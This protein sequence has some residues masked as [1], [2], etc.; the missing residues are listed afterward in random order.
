MTMLDRKLI[1]KS[2]VHQHDMS[3]C[4]TACL[5]TLIRYYGGDSS[6]LHLREISGTSNT[7][8]TLLGLYQAALTMGFD[9]NGAVANGIP[10]LIEHGKP[11]ILAVIVDKLLS[12]YVVCYGLEKDRFIISD[13]AKGIVEMTK[14]ELDSVWTKNCLLLEPNLNFERKEKIKGKKKDW[15]LNLIRADFGLLGSSVAFGLAIAVLGMVM[16]VFSQRLVDDVLPSHNMTKLIAGIV[17]VLFLLIARVVLTA[18]RGKL[19]IT[20]TKNFNNRI[21]VFFFDRLL[22]LPKSFFDTRKTGDMVARLNDTRRIQAV[23]GTVAGDTIIN[24]LI[25]LVSAAFLF[26]Y[27]WKVAVLSLLCMPVFYW[28]IS[29]SNKTIIKKQQEVMSSYAMSESGFINTIG[30]MADIKSFSRQ[31]EFLKLNE[32]LYALFQ[33]KAFG[34]GNTQIGIGFWAGISSTI[35][36]VALIAICSVFVIDESMTTGELMAVIGITGTLFPSVASIA[37]V[38]IPINEAKVA[39]NR[40]YEIVDANEEERDSPYSDTNKAECLELQN[41]SFRFV[42]RPLL[43]E[44]I[45]FP[46]SKGKITCIVGESGCGKSTLCQVIERF[47]MPES[48]RMLIDGQPVDEIPLNQWRNMV[49]YIPQ[50]VYIFNGTVL[51]NICLGNVPENINEIAAFCERYGFDKFISEL[52]NGLAT[53]VGEEGINLSGGQKQ[54]VAFA[55]ALYK[56]FDILV[57]DETTSAMDRRTEKHICTVLESIKKEH[58]ILFVTHRLETARRLGDNIVVME[59]GLITAMGGHAELMGSENFYQE[60]W[61]SIIEQEELV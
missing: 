26:F 44:N 33:D 56:P 36:Q 24:G 8:T 27:S 5:L 22:H 28:I 40:M 17:L 52:P 14:E 55:R 43:F 19:L 45:S 58:I 9:A 34:L 48:G 61:N 1:E 16:A 42:G 21:I 47:Y 10:D 31:N 50:D 2:F 20:Q 7:G 3:D 15:F 30:G 41:I 35:I 4:G 59:K 13:P 29:S 18:L 49:S 25:I 57:M 39:F 46:L 23:I 38:M 53:L 32:Q 11:C 37:L 6:I 60:Y 51:D 12:H 54:L